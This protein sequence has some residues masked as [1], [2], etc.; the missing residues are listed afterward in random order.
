M[1]TPESARTIRRQLEARVAQLNAEIRQY[2]QPIAR[3]DVQLGA[4][5]QERSDIHAALA[6]LAE[7]GSPIPIAGET[8]AHPAL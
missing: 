4:L 1:L 6:E 3:C 5:L 2:P 7:A 8:R